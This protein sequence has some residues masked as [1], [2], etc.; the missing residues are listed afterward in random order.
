M[1]FDANDSIKNFY[2]NRFSLRDVI[3]IGEKSYVVSTVELLPSPYSSSYETMIFE[4]TEE[5][6]VED[7][8]ERYCNR[9]DSEEEAR[10]G[11][12]WALKFSADDLYPNYGE[13]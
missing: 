9:Y 8:S 5:G 6:R 2:E 11:H 12:A 13:E 4:S 7:Y 3:K 10:Q 1:G